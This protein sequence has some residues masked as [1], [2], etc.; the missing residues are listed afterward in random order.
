MEPVIT[1]E[2]IDGNPVDIMYLETWDGLYAP[3]GV[4]R[5][6]GDGPF[7]LILLASGNGGEGTTWIRNAMAN[8]GY[9]VDRLV[10]AGY[11]TAWIRYRTEVELG[12]HDGGPLVRDVRQG[13]ELFNRSPLEYEDEIAIVDHMKAVEWVDADRIGLIGM[14]HGGEMVMKIT[15]EYHGVR[16]AVASEPASHEYL[17]L[18]PDETA[19]VNEETGL[20]D[21]ESMLMREVDKV[22][23]RIDHDLATERISGIRTPILVMGRETDEL[24]GIFRLTYDLLVEAGKEAD[25]VSYD[26]DL[27]GYLYPLRGEDGEYEVNEVQ[28]EAIAHVIDWLDRHLG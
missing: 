21:I 10:E 6:E 28:V 8:R 1:T 23:G 13:R 17:A 5:P 9:I 27:H 12:Y 20:R 18:T 22:R 2:T 25:W 26:H 19:H 11:A 14:S 15:S 16:A 24:Q 3:I 7:P 4:R